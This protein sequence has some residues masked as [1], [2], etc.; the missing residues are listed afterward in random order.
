MI[1]L[2]NIQKSYP[3]QTLYQ[4]L[5]LRLN[6]GD[7]VGLVGRNGT[8]KSTLFKLILGEEQPDSGDIATPKNYKIGA[9]KQYFDFKEKTLL[10]E[11]ATALS[12]DDKYNIYKAE[13]ILF[14]LGFSEEDL[15]KEPKSFSGGYQIRINLAKL[16]LTEPNMLLLIKLFSKILEKTFDINKKFISKDC[17]KN[18]ISSKLPVIID[19]FIF[20][21]LAKSSISAPLFTKE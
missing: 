18:H 10:D 9:L 7:K 3:T 19:S 16:L 21:L 13:K 5:N 1:E 12:E 4:D 17:L 20:E 15:Q 14:G 6:K 2:I 11:T 8:G